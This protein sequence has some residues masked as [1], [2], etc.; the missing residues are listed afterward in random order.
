MGFYRIHMLEVIAIDFLIV[1][2][3]MTG[4]GILSLIIFF[5]G[6]TAIIKEDNCW[7]LAFSVLT[8]LN[9]F[10]LLAGV[11]SSI[12][13]LSPVTNN[14][15]QWIFPWQTGGW[16]SDWV[17]Q[18]WS[19]PWAVQIRNWVLGQ[20]SYR[21][22]IDMLYIYTGCPKKLPNVKIAIGPSTS[23]YIRVVILAKFLSYR[24]WQLI[25]LSGWWTKPKKSRE[26]PG[27]WNL[28]LVS[29]L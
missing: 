27:T 12:R 29:G 7:L 24:E 1:P 2:I 8:T 18:C 9:F 23:P 21:Y 13:W 5:T 11:I 26:K 16:N 22:V 25:C 28:A 15:S 4:G 6:M 20:V 19:D 3:V 17:S 14:D 10:I